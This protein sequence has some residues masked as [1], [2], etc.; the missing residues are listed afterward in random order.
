MLGIEE[1]D[2]PDGVFGVGIAVPVDGVLGLG[3]GETDG[4][5]AA[6]AAEEEPE[7]AWACP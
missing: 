5:P 6:A 4:A 3:I 1:V 7:S 2:A